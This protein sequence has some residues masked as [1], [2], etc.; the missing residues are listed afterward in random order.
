MRI[1]T[2]DTRGVARDARGPLEVAPTGRPRSP[3]EWQALFGRP[4]ELR[5]EVGPGKGDWIREMATRHPEVNWLAIEIKRSRAVWIE[6]KL[7]R[8]GV[9]NVRMLCADALRQLPVAFAPASLAAVHVNFF[10]P[11]PRARHVRR[12]FASFP[13][14]N[15]VAQMLRVGGELYF[16]TDH[17]LRAREAH[18]VFASHFLLEDT[19][20]PER[21]LEPIPDYPQSIHERKFRARGR[22]IHFLRFRRRLRG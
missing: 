18:A 10:D 5:V 13:R 8:A 19:W 15:A 4:G 3:E 14:A 9:E 17:P 21:M 11:W 6:E 2:L 16:V 22:D 1:G 12:R 20:G 7:L